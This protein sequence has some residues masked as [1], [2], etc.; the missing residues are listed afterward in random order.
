MIGVIGGLLSGVGRKALLYGGIALAVLLAGLGALS[1]AR[2]AGAKA[3]QVRQMDRTIQAE[4]KRKKLDAEI[5]RTDS[6]DLD[7][8]LQRWQRPE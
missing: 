2:R 3:E 5:S 7:E 4:K 6:A 1:A 8:R